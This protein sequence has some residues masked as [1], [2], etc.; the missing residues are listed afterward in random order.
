MA[1]LP[2][3]LPPSPSNP[4]P[5]EQFNNSK[6]RDSITEALAGVDPKHG[7]VL[8]DVDN[9][10]AGVILVHRFGD[11]WAA[12]IADRYSFDEHSNTF[13]VAVRGSW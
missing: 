7:N 11:T 1:S 8:F 12:V 13:Q 4:L 5:I 3:Q 9:K 10:G 6:L 2:V